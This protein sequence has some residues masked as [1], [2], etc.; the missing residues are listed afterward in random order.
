MLHMRVSGD[1]YD[2]CNLDNV[3]VYNLAATNDTLMQVLDRPVWNVSP[4]WAG[5]SRNS[6]AFLRGLFSEDAV[7]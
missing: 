5:T 2:F 1:Y 6:P 3:H 7:C 4:A